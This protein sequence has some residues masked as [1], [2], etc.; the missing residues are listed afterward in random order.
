MTLQWVLGVRGSED[1][2]GAMLQAGRS[3]VRVSM[4]SLIIFSLSNPSSL[5]MALEFTHPLTEL[6]KK[7][8]FLGIMRGRRV[9]LT[10]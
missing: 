10:T 8:I 4:S 1:G 6:S 7:K 5:Y 2:W 9:R 3:R